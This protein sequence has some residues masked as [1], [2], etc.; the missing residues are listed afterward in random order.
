MASLRACNGR[1]LVAVV[2]GLLTTIVLGLGVWRTVTRIQE[3]TICSISDITAF[4]CQNG[5]T[6]MNGR[7]I[8][9]EEWK[10][11]RCTINNHCEKSNSENFTFE[12][13]P[14]GR[15]GHSVQTCGPDTPNAGKPM[16]TRL[17]SFTANGSITLNDVITG[18]CSET[19]QYLEAKL[20]DFTG[21][22]DNFSI[23]AQILTSNASILTSGDISSAAN[24]VTQ[25]LNTSRALPEAK[26]TAVTTVSQLLD[27]SEVVFQDTKNNFSGES[28]VEP[29]VA[30][31]SV[32]FLEGTAEPTKNVRFSVMKGS[33]KF[34]DSSS[35]RVDRN[36]DDLDMNER[37][38]LQILL[39][40]SNGNAGGCG[41]VVYQNNKFFQS[42]TFK[43]Y[44][45]FSQKIIS[46]KTRENGKKESSSV[47]M[48]YSQTKENKNDPSTSVEMA[49]NPE[50]DSQKFQIHSYACV[51]WDALENDWDTYGCHKDSGSGNL[52]KCRCNHT[53][54][55]AILMSF[56][57]NYKYSEPLNILSAVGCALS[58]TGLALTII[59]QIVTRNVRK[60][61]VT[62]VLVSLC[63]SMLV[64]NLLFVFGIENANKTSETSGSKDIHNQGLNKVPQT[65]K[66]D[67]KSNPTCTAVAALLHYFLLV[68]FVWTGI[69]ATQLYYLL[70]RTMKPL[71]RYFIHLASLVAWGVPAVMVA[72]T[73]GIIYAQDPGN[74]NWEL[75]YRQESFCWLETNHLLEGPFLWS[76]LIPV[77]IILIS[78]IT[79]FIIITVKV[80]WKNNQNLTSTKKSSFLRKIFS[81]LSIAVVFG[82]T[83]ILAYLMMID[84]GDRIEFSYIFCL[85]NSTQGLQIFILHTVRTKIFQSEASKMLRLMASSA[86][87]MKARSPSMAPLRLNLRM[88]NMLRAF[89]A[90]NEHFRLLEP[91]VFTEETIVSESSQANS[92]A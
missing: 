7:C 10:G 23:E 25:I 51:Y 39:S 13:I 46:T 36:V 85:F 48:A 87:R 38:E 18:N 31:Q 82:I 11:L 44:S 1:I 37:T 92:T 59:F 3:E 74:S 83:W 33:S 71:P 53:T 91:S 75:K 2:C 32:D 8:C 21:N 58:I 68:T 84:N 15:Y 16:A 88:Y 6:W 50:Y 28:V 34:L 78:N 5:G 61:S 41:F 86:R 67:P 52:L 9:P 55:F 76:F 62:W 80:L 35:T 72:V 73:L 54:N 63:T 60:T 89:P 30:V 77:T 79:I 19:L 22:P 27:A 17:C 57:E 90:L 47:E 24:V 42:K 81:T 64:F 20:Q 43:T 4:F 29:N 40:T 66:V 69:S 70:I 45:D 56:Q 65:D 26:K 14:V 12:K 49:I